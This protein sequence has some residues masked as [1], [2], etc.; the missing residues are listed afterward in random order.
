MQL[1]LGLE[2]PAARQ[3]VLYPTHSAVACRE[4]KKNRAISTAPSCTVHSY[5]GSWMA[6]GGPVSSP[7]PKRKLLR[8]QYRSAPVVGPSQK[9]QPWNQRNSIC[10]YG[11]TTDSCYVQ[12]M[13]VCT[14]TRLTNG[15]VS[16]RY[17]ITYRGHSRQA[18]VS[19][20]LT[21]RSRF[22]RPSLSPRRSAGRVI[23][24]CQSRPLG[25]QRPLDCRLFSSCRP[26]RPPI[27]K[28]PR[29]GS[30]G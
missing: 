18:L 7:A 29:L 3:V 2:C 12:Y 11:G 10:T 30:T 17:Q 19:N 14:A 26:Q 27:A 16:S 20:L 21:F 23:C 28:K 1:G 15:I 4:G 5:C 24:Q 13:H 9:G 22:P 25:F 8:S 6:G